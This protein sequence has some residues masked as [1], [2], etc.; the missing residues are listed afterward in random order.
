VIHI[1]NT[2]HYA[3]RPALSSAPP[4]RRRTEAQGTRRPDRRSRGSLPT[5]PPSASILPVTPAMPAF[6]AVS[7][8]LAELIAEFERRTAELDATPE[9]TLA[10]DR[11]AD[12][13]MRALD[14][15]LDHRPANLGEVA[16]KLEAL[17]PFVPEDQDLVSV[18]TII[19]DIRALAG[20]DDE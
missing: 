12:A 9:E 20:E 18:D 7:P 3:A 19:D 13:R 14:D 10:W 4:R 15:L 1:E 8:K 5:A 11:V 16:A 6:P 2:F 17:K